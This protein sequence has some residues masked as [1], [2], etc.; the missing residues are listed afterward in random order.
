MPSG[1]RLS[2]SE[3]AIAA[4]TATLRAALS[5]S[6]GVQ[7]ITT[8]P[9]DKANQGGAGQ[10]LNL[11]LYHLSPNAAWSNQ[12]IPKRVRAGEQGHPPLAVTLHYLLTVYGDDQ[13]DETDLVMLGKAMLS[14]HDGA[15]I[16]HE[17]IQNALSLSAVLSE[18]RL[19]RQFEPVRLIHD[20]F[21]FEEMSKLWTAFQT[22]YRTSKAFQA[23][24]VLLE[25]TKRQRTPFPV[26]RRGPED[27]GPEVVPSLPAQLEAIVYS[28]LRTRETELRAARLGDTITLRGRWLPG[29]NGQVLVRNPN[30]RPT[31]AEPEADIVARLRPLAGSNQDR[32]Y[33]Q[34]NEFAGN[35]VSGPLQ[36]MVE[37][38]RAS[39]RPRRSAPLYM[40]LAP[41][42]HNESGLTARLTVEPE[43]RKLIVRTV[44]PIARARDGSLPEVMLALTPTGAGEEPAPILAD[45]PIPGGHP[46]DVKFDVTDV[47]PGGYRVR[48]RIESVETVP[49]I[50]DG[51]H[52]DVDN[53][54]TVQL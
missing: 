27:K 12:D 15:V 50:R 46:A 5:E 35:W 25:S 48:L 39:G 9:P 6:V 36:V 20:N 47:P 8:L 10:R 52:V 2:V 17:Q 16:T 29:V 7:D 23:S 3:L 44:P 54:Q 32:L 18:S 45:E 14:L 42:I 51:M 19:E 53:L 41:R 30:R 22:P 40:A 24:P 11:F 33:V 34:L 28:D 4:V 26:L 37:T 31:P 43:G 21:S 49:V 1:R 13:T 38:A